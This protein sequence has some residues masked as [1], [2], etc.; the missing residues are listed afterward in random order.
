MQTNTLIHV[1]SRFDPELTVIRTMNVWHSF[2][3]KFPDLWLNCLR[4]EVG[5][6]H[7]FLAIFISRYTPG[8]STHPPFFP[9]FLFVV[10]EVYIYKSLVNLDIEKATW[11]CFD[12]DS[13]K[14]VFGNR[15]WP[16]LQML[17][18]VCSQNVI[19][20]Q[21]DITYQIWCILSFTSNQGRY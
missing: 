21:R 16:K 12:S 19:Y 13:R 8:H 20:G 14:Y 1:L 18:W 2:G 15:N 9:G 7:F 6:D 10:I 17:F 4:V 5:I 3:Y 11:L